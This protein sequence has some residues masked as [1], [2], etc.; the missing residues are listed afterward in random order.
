MTSLSHKIYITA[1]SVITLIVFVYLVYLGSS[2]YNTSMEERFFHPDH[3]LLN[4]S[5]NLGHGLGIVGS[6]L[7][8]IGVSSYRN[9]SSQA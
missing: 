6:L 4:P 9:V 3:T 8:I 5:S 7:M 2:Y 1:L